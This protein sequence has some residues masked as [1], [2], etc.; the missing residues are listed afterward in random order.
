MMGQS[1][2][3]RGLRV[4]VLSTVLPSC[5]W[6]G[7][8]Y[9]RPALFVYPPP[10]RLADDSTVATIMTLSEDQ[11]T[12]HFPIVR[13]MDGIVLMVNWSTICPLSSECDFTM[14]DHILRYWQARGKKVVLGVAT[15]G[16]P[17]RALRGR[18]PYF[19]SATPN[20]VLDQVTTY[21]AWSV[22]FGRINGRNSALARFPSYA[23]PVFLRLTARLVHQLSRYDGDPAISQIRISTGLLTEDNPSPAGPRWLIPKYTDR[24]W[25]EYCR[26]MLL[27]YRD[28]FHRSQLEFDMSFLGLAYGRGGRLERQAADA[29]VKELI[30]SGTFIAFNGL[31]SSTR[32]ALHASMS[33]SDYVPQI[34][35]WLRT[36]Q[37]HGCRIGLEGGPLSKENMQDI[38]AIMDAIRSIKPDRLV[39]WSFDVVAIHSERVP[40]DRAGDTALD[41]L[42]AQPT[43]RQAELNARELLTSVFAH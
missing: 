18:T 1:P 14:V 20:W 17:S 16:F 5:L 25:I 9:P 19:E 38:S 29:L 35:Q 31:R 21:S 13:E 43:A 36:A 24:D 42:K 6:A 39:L 32:D 4:V 11:S 3:L 23:D 28:N 37:V 41:W 30:M 33:R 34:L 40:H 27:L 2:L 22:A 15:V 26:K 12:I 8:A 7:V 10:A